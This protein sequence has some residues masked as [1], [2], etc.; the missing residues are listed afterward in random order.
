[1]SWDAELN[2]GSCGHAIVDVNFT[3]NVNP[4]IRAAADAASQTIKWYEGFDDLTGVE[5]RE[6]LDA[7]ITELEANPWDYRG[8]DAL[9]GWGTYDQLLPVLR[10]MRDAVPEYPTTWYVSG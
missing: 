4:M 2:C 9:N 1:M 8:M 5:G 7:V 3:H 6:Y 10:K